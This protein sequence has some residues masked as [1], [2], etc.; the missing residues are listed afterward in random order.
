MTGQPSAGALSSA[1]FIRTNGITG[2]S[3]LLLWKSVKSSRHFV[4]NILLKKKELTF[5]FF[6]WRHRRFQEDPQRIPCL[7]CLSKK[8]GFTI[9]KLFFLALF[10]FLFSFIN[11]IFHNVCKECKKNSKTLLTLIWIRIWISICI[12]LFFFL[13]DSQKQK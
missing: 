13:C 5:H 3:W 9:L 8:F 12:L 2:T 7:P 10:T 6:S 1:T 4:P 11:F